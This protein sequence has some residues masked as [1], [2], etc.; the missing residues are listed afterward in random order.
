MGGSTA[1]ACAAR[2]SR[3]RTVVALE[4]MPKLSE[5]APYF[6][7]LFRPFFGWRLVS[8]NTIDDAIV[9][10]S[11]WAG[12]AIDQFDPALLVP[13]I[14]V[15]IL[16]IHGER[17]RL[18]PASYSQRLRAAALPESRL[19]LLASNNH[20]D[21]PVRPQVFRSQLVDWLAHQLPDQQPGLGKPVDWHGD[22][23][24]KTLARK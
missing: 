21:L 12:C 13:K 9:Q 5:V 15:P 22:S 4:T 10:D 23:K 19:C 2:D 24:S 17:D 14:R 8:Q 20:F 11:K 1:L 18:V 16:F 7:K 6:L 3:I